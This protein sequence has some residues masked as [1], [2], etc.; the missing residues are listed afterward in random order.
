MAGDQTVFV[1]TA[2]VTFAVCCAA[3]HWISSAFAH[4]HWLIAQYSEATA[5]MDTRVLFAF[6]AG[7][8]LSV[9]LLFVMRRGDTTAVSSEEWRY[10]ALKEKRPVSQTTAV[11]RFDLGSPRKALNLPIGTHLSLRAEING[12]MIMRSYTPISPNNAPGYFD[13]M[14]KTYPQGNLSRYIAD[15]KPGDKIAIK[16]PRG[17]FRYQANMVERIGMIAGGTGLTPCLQVIEH[18]LAVPSDRTRFDLIYANVSVDEILMR[19]RID[20]LAKKHPD[21]FH[22]YYFLNE[23]PPG[24]TGGI[25]FVTKEA[26]DFYL[27]KATSSGMVLMCGPPP[28]MNAMKKHLDELKFT[29]P[30]TVS[31][32]GDQVF[33][34]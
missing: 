33:L 34:F 32:M 19:D 9:A 2:L 18:A 29:K 25:G 26:I 13:L 5:A 6:A 15:M 17:Q 4:K 14:I 28:M 20:A 8:V 21:R 23:G 11:Y 1:T 22:V 27:P 16:G 31:Q 30:R 3:A 24:W 10:V 12:R 7:L